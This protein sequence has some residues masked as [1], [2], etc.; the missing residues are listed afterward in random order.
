[1][2]RERSMM[3]MY[4]SRPIEFKEVIPRKSATRDKTVRGMVALFDP[5]TALTTDKSWRQD[6]YL[7]QE[8]GSAETANKG[9]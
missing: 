8:V 2:R 9:Q 1:M 6:T 7:N 4:A 3:M 5:F